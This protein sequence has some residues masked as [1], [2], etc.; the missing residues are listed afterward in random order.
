MEERF[1]VEGFGLSDYPEAISEAA[2]PAS[3]AL[4]AEIWPIKCPT[5]KKPTRHFYRYDVT[6]RGEKLVE[7]SVA[8]EYDLARALLARGIRGV[9]EIRDSV[10]GKARTLV[11]IERAAALTVEDG[12][13]ALRVVTYR[14][15][16]EERP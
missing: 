12:D 10:T 6:F 1:G 16:D 7:R 14:G 11:N 5:T 3:A 13:C 2:T 15:D 8:A 4:I 9:V